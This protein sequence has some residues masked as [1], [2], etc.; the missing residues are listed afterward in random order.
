M[1]GKAAQRSVVFLQVDSQWE[2]CSHRIESL[3]IILSVAETIEEG[4]KAAKKV[5]ETGNYENDAVRGMIR[6]TFDCLC[7]DL[8]LP[9][10]LSR[11]FTLLDKRIWERRRKECHLLWDDVCVL[12][13]NL[14]HMPLDEL[15]MKVERFLSRLQA[16]AVEVSFAVSHTLFL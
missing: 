8:D 16:L 12:K 10:L 13:K 2:D 14:P 6:D 15:L 11:G 1:V 7:E 4:L 3:N 5:V 9:E